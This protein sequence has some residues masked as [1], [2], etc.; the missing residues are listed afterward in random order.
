LDL[1]ADGEIARQRKLERAEQERKGAEMA[2]DI[3]IQS[4]V[5]QYR[6]GIA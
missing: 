4:K 3:E 5:D 6:G 1:L 2:L